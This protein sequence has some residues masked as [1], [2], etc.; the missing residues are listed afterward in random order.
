MV[1]LIMRGIA[2]VR[3]DP[4]LAVWFEPENMAIPIAVSQNSE[5]LRAMTTGLAGELDGDAASRAE[6]EL[7]GA[8]LLRCIVSFLAMP[9][10]SE[11]AE[12]A[13][14]ETFVVPLLDP[15]HDQRESR[16]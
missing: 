14:L 4:L 13:M 15:N 3:S 8:W 10:E 12:R 6:T 9:G 11:E 7:R 2:A 1:D 16:P 5:L